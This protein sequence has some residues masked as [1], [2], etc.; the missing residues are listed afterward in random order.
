MAIPES[1]LEIWARWHQTKKAKNTHERIRNVIRTY[2]Y[3]RD[4]DFEDY[5]QGS[6]KN[7]TNIWADTDVDIVV[8]LNSVFKRNISKFNCP[9]ARALSSILLICNLWLKRV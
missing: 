1:Q 3:T 9:T 4:Y 7:N 6:Y 8:Q 5:L 2:K